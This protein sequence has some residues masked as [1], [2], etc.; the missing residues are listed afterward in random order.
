ME[1][2]KG[3]TNIIN[4]SY[5]CT[6]SYSLM[7]CFITTSV[8]LVVLH[9]MRLHVQIVCFVQSI[10]PFYK[11]RKQRKAVHFFILEVAKYLAFLF[12][13]K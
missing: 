7:E 8:T 11:D 6:I 1:R 13:N 9:K 2:L 5:C 4:I 10:L 12:E 3:E